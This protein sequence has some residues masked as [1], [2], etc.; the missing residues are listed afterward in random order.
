[1]RLLAIC[2]IDQ[3]ARHTHALQRLISPIFLRITHP[4]D[5]QHGAIAIRQ[6]YLYIGL[7]FLVLLSQN[8]LVRIHQTR[9][10]RSEDQRSALL[11]L[12]FVADAENRLIRTEERHRLCVTPNPTSTRP[13]GCLVGSL[14][15]TGLEPRISCLFLSLLIPHLHCPLIASL[16]TQGDTRI[17]HRQGGGRGYPS[18]IPNGLPLLVR[19]GQAISGLRRTLFLRTHLP[20]ETRTCLV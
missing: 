18:R 15:Q 13:S 8:V 9:I 17:R 12:H 14:H 4:I 6:F 19:Q 20:T 2:L 10:V 7:I 1:M 3:R 11:H 5:M 16:R